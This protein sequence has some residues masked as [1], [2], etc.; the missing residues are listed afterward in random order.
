MP[1]ETEPEYDAT[2]C[3]TAGELRDLGIAIPDS[4][5]DCGWVKRSAMFFKPSPQPPPNAE[6]IKNNILRVD[7]SVGFHEPFHWISTKFTI[8]N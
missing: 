6:D 1:N 5:P 8:N 7:L 3:I 2:T 4:I